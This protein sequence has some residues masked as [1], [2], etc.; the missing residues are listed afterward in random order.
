[1]APEASAPAPRA[2]AG[3]AARS[4][5]GLP[6][7]ATTRAAA[8]AS[9]VD[10]L[11]PVL[12]ALALF[13]FV[14]LF[15]LGYQDDLGANPIEFITH[16]T[17]FWT[18]T[19]LCITLAITPMRRL[20]GWQ[21]LI[22]LRRMVGLFAFFYACA[23]LTTYVWFDQWFSIEE[24]VKDVWKRPFI[25]VG[26]AA[27]LLLVPLA[28]TSTNRMVRRLGRRWSQLHRL[29][30][31]VAILGVTHFWWLKQDKNDLAEPWLFAGI[32]LVLL[33]FRL[34]YPIWQRRR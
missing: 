28:I 26:F 8:K 25:T 32:V 17:G 20:T 11:K 6:K 21:M 16:S 4:A 14:R 7:A 23:H 2:A 10:R 33:T 22:R 29:I 24:I 27:F 3:S 1:M 31:L 5:A 12:F 15:V 9:V 13:P 19:F 30:Y 18:L 34:L